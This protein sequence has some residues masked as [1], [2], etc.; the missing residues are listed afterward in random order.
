MS[1]ESRQQFIGESMKILPQCYY[2]VFF[3]SIDIQWYN[4]AKIDFFIPSI[5]GRALSLMTFVKSFVMISSFK[6]P[7]LRLPRTMSL[8]LYS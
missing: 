3:L 8:Q 1:F 7:H 5:S 2:A 6:L 4:V